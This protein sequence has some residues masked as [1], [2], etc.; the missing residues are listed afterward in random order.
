M[1]AIQQLRFAPVTEAVIDFRA[2]L[3]PEFDVKKLD[4]LGESLGYAAP[5]QMFEEAWQLKKSAKVGSSSQVEL[6]N[7]GCIGFRYDSKDKKHV[8]QFRV[9]GFTFSRLAPY[10]DWNCVFS[11]AKRLYNIY[12]E[13]TRPGEISRIAVRYVNKLELPRKEIS[14]AGGFSPFLVNSP[15]LT[16]SDDLMLTGF[17]AQLKVLD[18]MTNIYGT[19]TQKTD[20]QPADVE[21]AAVILD[22]DV[23][24]M[25]PFSSEP[26]KVLNRFT[27]LREMK[28]RLFFSAITPKTTDLY[29]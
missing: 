28:N 21:N 29:K 17:L 19:I 15:T 4:R 2:Q 22:L 8:A 20:P 16:D 5:K 14:E 10:S 18:P 11:E 25:G 24:E 27:A 9:N 13:I 12:H 6:K 3:D 7:S 23:Y 26:A 1:F